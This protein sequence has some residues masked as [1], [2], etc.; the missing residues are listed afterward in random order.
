MSDVQPAVPRLLYIDDDQGLSRLVQK[1]MARHGFEVISAYLAA[2]GLALAADGRFD[3]IALDHF[4]PDAEGLEVLPSLLERPDAPP[5]VYVTGAQESRIAVAALKTGAADYVVKDV[6]ED[7]ASLLRA[8]VEDAIARAR[9][10]RE[11]EAAEAEVRAARDRAEVLLKEVNHRVGNSLQMV[12]SFIALQSRAL[13]DAGAR[14]ALKVTQAR[15]EAVAQV[16]R[17]LYTSQNVEA[18]QLDDYFTSL[19]EELRQSLSSSDRAPPQIRLE[20]EPISVPTDRAVSLGVVLT[21]LLTN[22]V[23]YA[24]PSGGGEIQVRLANTGGKG[25]LVV[26]DQGVGLPAD[27]GPKGTGLGRTIIGAMAQSLRSKVEYDQAHKGVRASLA[28]EA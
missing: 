4:L 17:R 11:K 21:E 5:V 22:A 12:S 15:I 16:H 8:A 10:R 3:C 6:A 26:E 1:E 2:D 27:G 28:F 23:K 14:E 9:L 13:T 24:Y 18:V 25:L 19:T 7:F 20:V